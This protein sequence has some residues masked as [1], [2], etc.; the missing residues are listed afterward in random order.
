M[1]NFDDS[2]LGRERV[3]TPVSTIRVLVPCVRALRFELYCSIDKMLN[4]WKSMFVYKLFVNL[5]FVGM[6]G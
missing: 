2:Y 6:V 3:S 1:I 4:V 5:L